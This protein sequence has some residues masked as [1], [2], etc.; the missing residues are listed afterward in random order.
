MLTEATL[1]LYLAAQ[2]PLLNTTEEQLKDEI[3]QQFDI[4]QQDQLIYTKGDIFEFMKQYQD[5][6][7]IPAQMALAY[8]Y[9]MGVG[10]LPLNCSA[11]TSFYEPVAT[12]TANQVMKTHGMQVIQKTKLK[13]DSYVLDSENLRIDDHLYIKGQGNIEGHLEELWDYEGQYGDPESLS[14]HAL[15]MLN[16]L[17][18]SEESVKR[19]IHLLIRAT[20]EKKNHP[21]SNYYLGLLHMIGLG[22]KQDV[23]KAYSY[24]TNPGLKRDPRALNA[25]GYIYA[26]APHFLDKDPSRLSAFGDIHQDLSKAHQYF[27]EASQVGSLN[28][29]FNLGNLYLREG[30]FKINSKTEGK[31]EFSYS[32]AYDY[33]RTAAEK[34]HTLAAYNLGVMHYM[35][36]GTFQSCAVA[37][38]F[39]KQVAQ[40]GPHA[41]LLPDGYALV[42]EGKPKAAL[43]KYM[44]AAEMGMSVGLLNTAHLLHS[45]SVFDSKDAFFASEVDL[46]TEGPLDMNKYLAYNY[47]KMA[48]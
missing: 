22:V 20:V 30:S 39:L 15:S 41:R 2:K 4:I 32:K 42:K 38:T 11:S 34:G 28:A 46:H 10:G 16:K 29:K 21:L 5:E 27:L 1:Q 48:L 47:Y 33:F 43:L 7:R 44:E 45:N 14:F 9:E 6:L 37:K 24:F 13:I 19:A 12:Y 25:L 18:P 26:S 23:S 35:S 3:T 40:V 31:V 36:L 17:D 8:R